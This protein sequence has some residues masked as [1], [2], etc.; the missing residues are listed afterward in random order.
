[1]RLTLDW[2]DDDTKEEFL[3]QVTGR[4]S[5]TGEPNYTLKRSAGGDGWHYIEYDAATEWGIIT[6]LRDRYG[7]DSNRIRLDLQREMRG[8]PF[9]QVLFEYKYLDRLGL[10]FTSAAGQ[11]TVVEQASLSRDTFEAGNVRYREALKILKA[12]GFGPNV[13]AATLKD[14]YQAESGGRS[15]STIRSYIRGDRPVT[16]QAVRRITRRRLRSQELGHFAVDGPRPDRRSFV[17]YLDIT[18][19]EL[20]GE[21]ELEDIE[22]EY[23]LAQVET[24]TLNENISNEFLKDVHDDLAN[25]VLARLSPESP[26]TGE[27][28]EHNRRN[29]NALNPVSRSIDS[30]NFEDEPLDSDEAQYYMDNL[31][32]SDSDPSEHIFFEVLLFDDTGSIAWQVLGLYDGDSIS[33]V[34][35]LKDT[36]GWY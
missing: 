29:E 33:E 19:K 14:S 27:V 3:P 2:D 16:S 26:L 32:E 10:D 8:S 18:W 25:E 21:D 30:L 15:A 5:L 23:Y 7:D 36:N 35:I 12:N 34:T 20:D 1:M 6:E 9:L 11:A 22:P 17:E 31:P 28:L 24:G 13:L 4:A